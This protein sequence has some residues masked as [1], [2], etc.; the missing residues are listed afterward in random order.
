MGSKDAKAGR[1]NAM[2]RVYARGTTTN[3]D[4]WAYNSDLKQLSN[5]MKQHI[6]YCN[7]QDW[8]NPTLDP[9]QAKWDEELSKKLERFGQQKFSKSKIRISLY[10]PFFKQ[11]LYFD[12]I[13]NPR[14]GITPTTFPRVD[15]TNLVICVPYKFTGKFSTFISDMTT[16]LELIHHSQC[17]PLY[18]YTNDKKQDNI[19]NTT[20]NEYQAHYNDY[21]I[22]K[23][24]IFYY[25]YS[26][27][28]HPKYRSKYENN[29][30]RELPRIPMAPD[31]WGFSRTGK[32][33]ADLHLSWE[34]CKRYDLGAPKSEFGKYH[35]MAFGKKKRPQDGK[36]ET[37]YSVLKINGIIV[38]ENIPQ[39]KY[40]VNGRSPLEWA[41]DRYK[42]RQDKE[43]G[44]INDATGIDVIPLV[45]RL[46][47][48]GV[49]SD[50]L[51]DMLPAVFEPKNW[52][53]KIGLNVFSA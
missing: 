53:P 30:S 27:L 37:D 35:K 1:R 47:Y 15:S 23:L 14:Q 20:L 25:V 51:I 44:I 4:V 22:T 12:H 43:S 5:H 11:W 49:E 33:L 42:I 40:M 16:D 36:L 48:V 2:F 34:S 7:K 38:F 9:K 24:D 32:K 28:H 31:F 6:D 45:E 29:L 17:F 50:R 18:T 52:E 13:F 21:K 19:T 3:R 10:R 41:I 8:K 39:I 46:V 26:L